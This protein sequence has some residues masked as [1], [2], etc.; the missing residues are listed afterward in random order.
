MVLGSA[1]ARNLEKPFGGLRNADA[2]ME[3]YCVG[4]TYLCAITLSTDVDI[5]LMM[6]IP[7]SPIVPR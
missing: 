3:R 1:V 6:S 2:T 7:L 5:Y 4:H